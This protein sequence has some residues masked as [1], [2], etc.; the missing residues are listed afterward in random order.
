MDTKTTLDPTKNEK[1]FACYAL[2]K[3]SNIFSGGN[4]NR[5][6]F[7]NLANEARSDWRSL[8][9]LEGLSSMTEEDYRSDFIDGT[10]SNFATAFLHR[11]QSFEEC[12][13]E[14]IRGWARETLLNLDIS[15]WVETDIGSAID[16]FILLKRAGHPQAQT[17]LDEIDLSRLISCVSKEPIA[18]RQS[19]MAFLYLLILN[20][21]RPDVAEKLRALDVTHWLKAANE[22]T[23]FEQQIALSYLE[24]LESIGNLQAIALTKTTK[25]WLIREVQKN[26]MMEAGKSRSFFD[27]RGW[28]FNL[29]AIPY[30]QI[31]ESRIFAFS[32]AVFILDEKFNKFSNLSLFGM[33]MGAEFLHTFSSLSPEKKLIKGGVAGAGFVS[34]K[35]VQPAIHYDNDYN[36]HYLFYGLSFNIHLGGGRLREGVNSF[37]AFDALLEGR[38]G[39]LGL[40]VGGGMALENFSEPVPVFK[41]AV[42]MGIP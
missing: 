6:F 37:L 21:Y 7:Q 38:L 18:A 23:P 4:F 5:S 36:P 12:D 30:E 34:F 9:L 41:L 8:M 42:N 3:T 1:L 13:Y 10:N 28:G 25:A 39:L 33:G 17:A 2:H 20:A 15:L 27:S 26:K 19:Q 32:F 14:M 31:G 16:A 24:R 40:A 35:Y 22:G 29:Q 11:P